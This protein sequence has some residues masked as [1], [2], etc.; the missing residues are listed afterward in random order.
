MLGAVHHPSIFRQPEPSVHLQASCD[1]GAAPLRHIIPP[2]AAPPRPLP[3]FQAKLLSEYP[4]AWRNDPAVLAAAVGG[5]GAATSRRAGA[6]AAVAEAAVQVGAAT[7]AATVMMLSPVMPAAA[8]ALA[9]GCATAG[10][11]ISAA[12]LAL[13]DLLPRPSH[14]AAAITASRLS[15]FFAQVLGCGLDEPRAVVERSIARKHTNFGSLDPSATAAAVAQQQAAYDDIVKAVLVYSQLRGWDEPTSFDSEDDRATVEN[16]WAARQV[17]ALK[18]AID[19][20]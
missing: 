12:V 16:T 11:I 5:G 9:S 15:F 19:R 6:L 8:F 7:G 1:A 13:Q 4:Q 14:S 2:P 20:A 3:T 10:G 18:L 17:A